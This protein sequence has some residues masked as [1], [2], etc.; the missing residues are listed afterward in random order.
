MRGASTTKTPGTKEFYARV[1][2]RI[3]RHADTMLEA[4]DM[5][6]IED[7]NLRLALAFDHLEAMVSEGTA[8]LYRAALIDA[9]QSNPGPMDYGAMEILRPEP[10]DDTDFQL[11]RL[12]KKRAANLTALRG[13]Q[14]KANWVS[15]A[16]WDRLLSAIGASESMWS[17]A[18]RDWILATLSTGLRP[19]EWRTACLD[20][21][22][23]VVNNGKHTNGRAHS[24]RRTIDLNRAG[25]QARAQ[26]QAF[27]DTVHSLGPDRFDELYDGV[28][29]LIY[30]VA[31]RTFGGR[32]RFPTLYSARHC[33]AAR[34]KSTHSKEGVAA[35]MGHASLETAGR[36]YAHARHARGGSPLEAEPSAADI[37]AVRHANSARSFIAESKGARE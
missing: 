15:T 27:L 24:A 4:G 2:A 3:E 31:R 9:V 1:V 26:I 25:Y 23:L 16:D 19:S 17:S 18:A 11:E 29:A 34:A 14:Q 30:V 35:L 6:F 32:S 33:F 21:A 37:A 22:Q 5:V 36:H 8:R 10:S 13:P 20:G 12:A 28:R 7:R